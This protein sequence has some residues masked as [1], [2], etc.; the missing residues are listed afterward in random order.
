[1]KNKPKLLYPTLLTELGFKHN[2]SLFENHNMPY[3][4]KNSICLWYNTPI[5]LGMES[6]YL[7]GYAE[8]RAGKYYAVSFRWITKLK[9]LTKIYEAITDKNIK[10]QI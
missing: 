1:M 3:Y 5:Q 8:M 4:V 6:S 10:Q 7:I 9:E 2:K